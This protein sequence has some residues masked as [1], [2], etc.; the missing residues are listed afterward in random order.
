M[1]DLEAAKSGKPIKTAGG[2]PVRLIAHVPQAVCTQRVVCLINQEIETYSESG[3]FM[4]TPG[5]K[6]PMDLVT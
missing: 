5:K 2:R 4:E 1:F 3:Q 6:S